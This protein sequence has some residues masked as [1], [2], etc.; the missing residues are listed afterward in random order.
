[1]QGQREVPGEQFLKRR[2]ARATA[3]PPD[4][5]SPEVAAFIAIMQLPEQAAALLP[6]RPDGSA[7]QALLSA[8]EE[9]AGSLLELEPDS[10]KWHMIIGSHLAVLNQTQRAMHHLLRCYQLAR[11]QASDFHA[12]RAAIQAVLVVACEVS[13]APL[14]PSALGMR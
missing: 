2:L 10:P 13:V 14:W 11:Q 6:L 3:L 12:A 5:R 7:A 4:Q 1:M 8:L 9:A